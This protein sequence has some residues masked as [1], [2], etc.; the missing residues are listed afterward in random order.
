MIIN[1]A[2]VL[3]SGGMD[4]V[5]ALC[6]AK[7]RYQDV[8]AI[9]FDYGQANRDQEL[10]AA[11]RLCTALGVERELLHCGDTIARGKGILG[12]I[13][14]HDGREDGTSPNVVPNRNGVLANAAGSHIVQHFPNGNLALILGCNAQDAKR[15]PDCHPTALQAVGEALRHTMAREIQIVLPWIVLTKTQILQSLNAED[16][17]HVAGSWSCY[18]KVGPC[19]KCS[20]CVLRAEAFTAVGLVDQ[21][22]QAVMNGGDPA[23]EAAFGPPIPV[24]APEYHLPIFGNGEAPDDDRAGG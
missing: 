22:V 6:W 5:A 17:A 15:Y 12:K 4:S 9:L 16:R 3:L 20:A 19:G 23:R 11:G 8:W 24:R 14:D 2:C 1:Q 10:T 21:C 13:Q 7:R 18:R